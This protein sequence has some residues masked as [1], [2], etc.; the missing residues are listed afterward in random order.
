MSIVKPT[1]LP[2][3]ATGELRLALALNQLGVHRP[4]LLLFR[5]ASRL[6]DGVF[7]YALMSVLALLGGADGLSAATHMALTGLV[8]AGLY[9]AMKGVIRRPR[10]FRRHAGIVARVRPL[11]EF[12]FP[13][14]HTL[15]AVSF[16][17]VA[18]AWYPFLAWI[19]LPFTLLVAASRVIL[20][21][22]YPSDVLAACAIGAAI[23]GVSLSLV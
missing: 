14:G 20:G 22:H 10:P 4:V 19:L 23:A 18:I 3:P 7:W 21:V 16:S 13:S 1:L 9:R 12:S 8:V 17:L 5:A 6:G 11:D 15:H 2:E